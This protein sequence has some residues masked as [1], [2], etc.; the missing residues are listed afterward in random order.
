MAADSTAARECGLERDVT[1]PTTPA[2]TTAEGLAAELR[3]RGWTAWPAAD[4]PE[5]CEIDVDDQDRGVDLNIHFS[6]FEP[7]SW[8]VRDRTHHASACSSPEA[9]A[10]HVITTIRDELA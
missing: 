2:T 8:V 4:D 1:C 3:S 5:V 9:L 10:E 7:P 6:Q